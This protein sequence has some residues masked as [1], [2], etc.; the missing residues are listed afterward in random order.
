MPNFNKT[1]IL[2]HAGRDAE[3]HFAA[4]GTAV[5][6]L[7]IAYN[8]YRKDGEKVALWFDVVFFGKTAERAAAITKGTAIYVEGSLDQES[9]Q[10]K[11]TGAERTKLVIK[12]DNFQFLGGGGNPNGG[13]GGV[14]KTSPVSAGDGDEVPF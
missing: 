10:D 8:P 12:A 6:K 1:I 5:T 2:G 4:S 3:T 11:N 13:Q 9:W 14:Q 7:S